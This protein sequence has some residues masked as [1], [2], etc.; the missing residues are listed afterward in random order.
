[1]PLGSTVSAQYVTGFDRRAGQSC[2]VGS[3]GR[4]ARWS[5]KGA[6]PH[7]AQSRGDRRTTGL[8]ESQG[9]REIAE[10]L[11]MLGSSVLRDVRNPDGL[12]RPLLRQVAIR[13]AGTRSASVR[14]LASSYLT[15]DP[16]GPGERNAALPEAE[17]RLALEAPRAA[18]AD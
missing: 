18:A 6:G 14:R 17:P 12:A 7:G 16:P 2:G 8:A 13:L 11:I 3:L 5:G 15:A 9:H 1:M 4:M 10:M